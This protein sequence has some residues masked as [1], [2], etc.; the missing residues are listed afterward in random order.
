VSAGAEVAMF[1]G[2]TLGAKFDGE[3]AQ[4]S[5]IYAVSGVIRFSW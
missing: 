2:W 4:N 3:F 5:Q 1:S